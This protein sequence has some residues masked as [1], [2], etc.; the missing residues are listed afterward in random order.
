M[1]INRELKSAN[2]KKFIKEITYNNRNPQD[3]KVLEQ[4]KDFSTNPEIILHNGDLLY[5]ARIIK[6]DENITNKSPFYGLS[7]TESFVAPKSK[8]RD[9]RANYR[10]IP[11]LY[12]S[13]SKYIAS[14]EVRPK[15]YSKV[16]ISTIEVKEKMTI[17]DLTMRKFPKRM[18]ESKINLF[19]DLSKLYSKPALDD[20][21]IIDYIPTQYIAEY[22]KNLGYDGLAYIS[23]L[24]TQALRNN[25][26]ENMNYVIFNYNKCETIKSN[27]YQINDWDFRF[28]Q[29]DQDLVRK[30]IVSF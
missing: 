1:V 23:S 27:I 7:K 15:L 4:I 30:S 17:L 9:M 24:D 12:C 19:N 16:N 3:N 29:I 6:N 20:D 18:I 2:L 11:Y 8:T 5:R 10:Y 22:V 13:N 26:I 14:L 28:T 25:F 21:D